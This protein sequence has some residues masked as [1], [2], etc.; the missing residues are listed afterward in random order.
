MN[1]SQAKNT[2]KVYK[3]ANLSDES[4]SNTNISFFKCSNAFFVLYYIKTV[5][6]SVVTARVETMVYSG[7]AMAGAAVNDSRV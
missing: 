1:H 6:I 7:Q 4:H 3:L 2:R 5:L